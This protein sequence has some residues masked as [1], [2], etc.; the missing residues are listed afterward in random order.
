MSMTLSEW[1][2]CQKWQ[3]RHCACCEHYDPYD[4][5]CR[6]GECVKEEE[7]EKKRMSR[8]NELKPCP[9]CGTT[10]NLMI[11][12]KEK[13]EEYLHTEYPGIKVKH[14]IVVWCMCKKCHLRYD[15]LSTEANGSF[16]YDEVFEV[17]KRKWN[18]LS[19]S[20]MISPEELEPFKHAVNEA[21]E[22]VYRKLKGDE[23][24]EQQRT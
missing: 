15:A 20:A 13:V 22:N 16:D 2:K 19:D 11:N 23:A 12:T 6:A 21:V 4:Y 10:E 14:G 17:L 8:I 3:M 1:I 9:A 24:D 18:R 7:E 5:S